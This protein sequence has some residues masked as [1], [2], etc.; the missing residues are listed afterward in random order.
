MKAKYWSFIIAAALLL[1][2]CT[3]QTVTMSDDT[4]ATVEADAG[5]VAATAAPLPEGR[6]VVADGELASPYPNL[7]LSFG[8]GVSG[9]VTVLNIKAGD[10]VAAGD[11]IAEL[12]T[13]DLQRAVDNA[14]VTL[15][16]AKADRDQAQVQWERD[17]AEAEQAVINAQRAIT[18]TV[19]QGSN[20]TIEEAR[21]ALERARKTEDDAWKTY[22][23]PLFGEWT[24]DDIKLDNYNAWLSARREREL[25]EMRLRDA[26]NAQGVRGLDRDS[27]ESDLAQAERKLAAL[28]DGVAPS[29]DRAI[30]DAERELQKAQDALPHATLT[31][32]W[33]ALVM[34]LSVAPQ[35]QVAAGSPVVTLL[36]LEDGLRF[37]TQNLS[38]QHVA[39]IRPGQKATVTLRTFPETPLEGTVEA[40]VPQ[41]ATQNA[42]DA[43][44]AIHIRLA[45]TDL[46]LL[47][48]LTG[49]VE[50]LTEE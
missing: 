4:T 23:T 11:V 14:E 24:P 29:Y 48:G 9:Q 49:R 41:A 10:K 36:S 33:P 6:T 8:G 16:R 50:I 7:A 40:I 15:A 5:T 44:F 2:A 25:A 13:T 37:V 32:P 19:L 26:L 1:T 21:T 38:E 17:V 47:P 3:T 27:R 18:S 28:Q 30:E 43:R 39:T 35:A 20:T 22:Q 34:S 45:P 12:D 46:N 31:A 42:T